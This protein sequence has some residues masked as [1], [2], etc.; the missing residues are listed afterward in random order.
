MQFVVILSQQTVSLV[1]TQLSFLFQKEFKH[2]AGIHMD[3]RTGGFLFYPAPSRD[4]ATM[5]DAAKDPKQSP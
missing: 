2:F 4:K 1:A 5:S 3:T